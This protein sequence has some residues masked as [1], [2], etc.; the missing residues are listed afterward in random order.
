MQFYFVHVQR[1]CAKYTNF[2]RDTNSI[3]RTVFA[4]RSGNRRTLNIIVHHQTYL[5][6]THYSHLVDQ[7][8]G[9]VLAHRH[10]ARRTDKEP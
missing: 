4:G 6:E 1:H 7:D 9:K 10:T 5:M 8:K 2:C 3:G